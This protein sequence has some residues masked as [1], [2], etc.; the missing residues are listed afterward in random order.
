MTVID[1]Q[2]GIVIFLEGDLD[3]S[4]IKDLNHLMIEAMK[5]T[6]KITFDL[7][8]LKFIDSSGVGYVLYECRKMIDM[9]YQLKFKHLS[10][11]IRDLFSLLGVFYILGDSVFD[12]V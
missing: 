10:D 12:A 1:E 7:S 9:G 3:M 4:G 11:E 6:K 8:G 2:K 5:K